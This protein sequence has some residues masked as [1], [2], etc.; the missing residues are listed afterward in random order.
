[1]CRGG[2]RGPLRRARSIG[3]LSAEVLAI[4]AALLL[5]AGGAN[6]GR[7]HSVRAEPGIVMVICSDGGA[8][9]VVLDHNGTPVETSGD[10]ACDG[11]CLCCTVPDGVGLLP[12]A[13]ASTAWE[14]LATVAVF[15][16]N[17]MRLRSEFR[18]RAHARAPPSEEDA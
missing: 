8:K 2:L 1:M 6:A 9:T 17:L 15:P 16:G 13:R 5:A 4:I 11:L 18:S 12:D 7:V 10:E 14:P 3:S